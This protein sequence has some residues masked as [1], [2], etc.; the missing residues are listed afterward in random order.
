MFLYMSLAMVE[1]TKLSI[2]SQE[3][4]TATNVEKYR[5]INPFFANF[6]PKKIRISLQKFI[7]K[8][9]LNIQQIHIHRLSFM[10]NS[11]PHV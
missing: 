3:Y 5:L 8:T 10:L 7:S 9:K 11:L 2:W 1:N 4:V 6:H